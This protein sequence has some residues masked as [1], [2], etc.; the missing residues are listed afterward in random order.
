MEVHKAFVVIPVHNRIHYTCACLRSLESQTLQGINVI[1]VNDGSSDA[2]E[3]VLK[4]QF[5]YVTV[6]LGDGNLWWTGA[7][8]KGVK[9]ANDRGGEYVLSLN[10]DLEVAKDY[11]EKMVYWAKQKPKT[12][13]GSYVFDIATGEP[14]FGG[15]LMDWR[16]AKETN[17]LDLLPLERRSGL[18]PVTHFPGRGLW[19]PME[20]FQRIGFFDTKNFP[21]YFADYDFT[22]RAYRAGFE[23]Y[24]N[25]DA[26]LH[27]HV[28]ASGD[29]QY[30]G[31]FSMRNYIHH[32]T[33]IKGRGN[34]K[35]FTRFTLKNCPSKYRVECLI[36][37]TI[38]R[39]GGYP[40]RYMRHKLVRMR[41]RIQ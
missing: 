4:D 22:L 38:A 9:Y 12:I 33:H 13:L 5:P 18:H 15:S 26:R 35:D 39:L 29:P 19:L 16:N 36:K 20:V 25:F 24:T 2:T 21:H 6:L 41:K 7:M 37:G 1:V 34:L 8:N 23:L 27:S 11:V 32:L 31:N 40:L 3:R 14:S 10:N 28:E 30:R 17:L